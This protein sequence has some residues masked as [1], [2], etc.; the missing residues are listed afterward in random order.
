VFGKH[1]IS[2]KYESNVV[3]K[4][5]ESF[6]IHKDWKT[7]TTPYD[8]DIAL[9]TLES[10]VKF[11]PNIQP[12]CLPPLEWKNKALQEGKI[13]GWGF[14]ERSDRTKVEDIPRKAQINAPPTN[15]QCFL[16]YKDLVSLSS[17]RTFCAGGNKI[18]PCKGDS[19]KLSKFKVFK[20]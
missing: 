8:G 16:T 10:D 3:H 13:V 7:Y 9:L 4:N 6:L 11:K 17:N 12:I 20:D 18:G 5:V 19:G 15:E 1:N 2:K 14:S